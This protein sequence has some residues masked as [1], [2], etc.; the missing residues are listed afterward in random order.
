[1]GAKIHLAPIHE[2][3][4]IVMANPYQQRVEDPKQ[5]GVLF[6]FLQSNSNEQ[7]KLEG[8]RQSGSSS[9][10]S[11]LQVQEGA[12]KGGA[13]ASSLPLYASGG[14]LCAAKSEQQKLIQD[15]ELVNL[16][17]PYKGGIIII[18]KITY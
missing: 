4:N 15:L 14:S 8:I 7:K 13:I 16:I 6:S 10:A 18:S 2:S 1:M 5:F 3:N 17:S 12:M 9:L 11:S